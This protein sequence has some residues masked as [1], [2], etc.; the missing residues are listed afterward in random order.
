MTPAQE[1]HRDRII[2]RFTAAF[3]A[4]YTKG[5]QEHGGNMWTKPGMLQHAIEEVT[6]LVAYLYTLED[7]LA[8]T[9]DDGL[10]PVVYIGGP[11][12]GKDAWEIEQNIRRAEALALEAWRA[13]CAVI[14]PHTNTRFFQGAA[15]DQTWLVGDLAILGRC[16]AL[17]LTPD[18]DRSTGASAE[19]AFAVSRAMPVFE[20]LDDLVV[21]LRQRRTA[22]THAV[23]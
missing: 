22:D 9:A 3:A 14:C 12:R 21:W 4:K 5:Q 8:P 19:R 16:D 6:D 1:A 2:R 17:L 23:A 11:F 15:D 20:Q 18:W 7:Q 10:P 13:G